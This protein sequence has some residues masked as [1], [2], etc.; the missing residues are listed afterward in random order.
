ME[1]IGPQTTWLR[2]NSLLQLLTWVK[3]HPEAQLVSACTSTEHHPRTKSFSMKKEVIIQIDWL[4]E[5][6]SFEVYDNHICVGGG[7]TVA[8]LKQSLHSI[9]ASLPSKTVDLQGP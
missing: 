6:H 4:K 1:F 8:H 9:L 3:R 7:V 5:L 2:P